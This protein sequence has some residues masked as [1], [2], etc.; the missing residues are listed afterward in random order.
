ML[1]YEL[2][3]SIK[4]RDCEESGKTIG[5][6]FTSDLKLMDK[7]VELG[8][9]TKLEEG[10]YPTTYSLKWKNLFPH[11]NKKDATE[12]RTV[13]LGDAYAYFK[14]ETI[15]IKLKGEMVDSLTPET[16]VT[17]EAWDAS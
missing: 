13:I 11:I 12:N 9:A 16:E 3:V 2:I 17:V 4:L 1:G 8:L 7:F 5:T 10:G 14:T 6:G 15:S